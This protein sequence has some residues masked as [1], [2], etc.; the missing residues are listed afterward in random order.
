M[1]ESNFWF[2]LN[3]GMGTAWDAQRHEDKWAS[4]I[5]DVSFGIVGK[6]GKVN[7]WIELKWANKW[8]K[9]A[10]DPLRLDHYTVEQ[11]RWLYK[12]YQFGGNTYLALQVAN[13]YFLFTGP[14]M[15]LVG[16]KNRE[17][18]IENSIGYWRKEIDFGWFAKMITG[19]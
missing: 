3:T 15:I 8:P 2:Y 19:G 7:G 16:R 17:W 18:L 14:Q 1:S 5:P 12:R 9:K 6:S 10:S 11:R 13:E 4:G